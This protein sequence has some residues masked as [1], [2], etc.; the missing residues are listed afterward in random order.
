MSEDYTQHEAAGFIDHG[1]DP[2]LVHQAAPSCVTMD[3]RIFF[4][5]QALS[6]GDPE[7]GAGAGHVALFLALGRQGLALYLTPDGAR[8]VAAA[9]LRSAANTEARS[10]QQAAAQLAATLAKRTP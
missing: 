3:G 9:L 10:A 8:S 5:A 7:D 4:A 6:I 2:A 1:K